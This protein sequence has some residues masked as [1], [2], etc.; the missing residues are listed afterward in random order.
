MLLFISSQG[1]AVQS[2]TFYHN[3][4]LG[5][6]VAATDENGNICWREDYQ[7]YGEKLNNNDGHEP[8]TAGCGLDDNQRGY[9]GHVHD[10]DIGLTYMQARY[11]DP[12]IGRFMGIDPIGVQLG[13]QVSF[14]RY[15]YG[16]NNP[17]KYIDPD[18]M[19]NF[20]VG[21][22]GDAYSFAGRQPTGIM[23][24]VMNN[25]STLF[26]GPNHYRGY[27]DES[28]IIDAINKTP[29]KHNIVGHSWG[30]AAGIDITAAVDPGKVGTL[31]TLD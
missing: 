9:T 10:K 16:G 20:W 15:A 17:Y 26:S 6:P 19:D 23:R 1:F 12:V 31:I 11:Y 13:D 27:E 7:P 3:D 30:G 4:V 5:S 21:G 2:I 22:A 14:N 25:N 8:S 29:G 18:G 28:A 24:R